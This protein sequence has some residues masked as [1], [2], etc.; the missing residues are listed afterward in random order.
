[1]DKGGDTFACDF[2]IARYKEDLKW[3]DQYSKPE[4]HFQT[5][6]L[7]NKNQDDNEKTIEDLGC[8]LNAEKHVKNNLANEG[9]CDHTYLYHIIKNYNNLA[10]V[11]IFT[12]GSSDLHRERR[13]LPFIV[14]KAFETR[15]SVFSVERTAT[16]IGHVHERS[17]QMG[18]Y[19]ASHPK[20]NEGI[21]LVDSIKLKLA[22]PRPFGEWFKKHFP[23]INIYH[24]SHAGV[25]AVS[26]KHIRK[27]P[28][29]YYE[30]FIKE[31]EGHPN[32]EVGHYFERSWLA[33]FHPIPDSCIYEGGGFTQHGGYK[34]RRK[35]KR[36]R[37]LL[38]G[39]RV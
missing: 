33:L 23:D 30:A 6:Y 29:E 21:D 38:H 39:P 19:R 15:D 37:R 1:M 4:Y 18:T 11:T 36:R 5:V 10:D 20:N 27:F 24:V 2:V 32:P 14:K 16:A 8:H 26:R 13:K 28:V 7:Y 3:M 25:M 22:S 12:K 9:R 35:T 17:F 31:L 34:K